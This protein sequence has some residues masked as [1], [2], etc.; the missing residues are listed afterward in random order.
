MPQTWATV[1]MLKEPPEVVRDF[2]AHH[3]TLG[4]SEVHLYFDDPDDPSIALVSH[5]SQVRVVRCTPG[6]WAGLAGRLPSHEARQKA[7]ANHALDRTRCDWIIHLDADEMV[8]GEGEIAR[9]L[10]DAEGDALR[11]PPFEALG[12]ERA[13]QSGRPEFRFRGPLPRGPRGL[14]IGEAAYGEFAG[15]LNQ[16]MLGHSAGKFFVRTRAEGLRLSIHGPFRNGVRVPATDAKGM[17]LLH[18]HGADWA[19][20]RRHLEFRLSSGA[21][22]STLQPRKARAAPRATLFDLLVGLRDREGEEGLRRFHRQVCTFGPE[23]RVLGRVG[24]LFE[25]DLWL[26]D[27]RSQVFDTSDRIPPG[28]WPFAVER[29]WRGLALRL[30]PDRCARER[31]LAR[32]RGFPEDAADAFLRA[33]AGR[34]LFMTD[35][36]PGLGLF[37]LLAARAGAAGSRV[38]VIEPDEVHRARLA[39]RSA[40]LGL[41][42]TIG[43]QA[44]SDARGV[45][46]GALRIVHIDAARLDEF[47]DGWRLFSGSADLVLV[48]QEAEVH[49]HAASPGRP[50][51]ADYLTE[52][53]TNRQDNR[54]AARTE[55]WTNS[56]P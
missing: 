16:G 47:G 43:S 14:R 7:N 27:K 38:L 17:R 48:S 42:I 55:P 35:F 3:V 31:S 28:G 10:E 18:F 50:A 41:G 30:M 1:T 6:H 9:C 44:V 45:P 15:S 39:E 40:A 23:K 37:A 11:L 2:V 19:K 46:N 53:T 34:V 20:W 25:A 5:I 26:A 21:Y 32:G 4:A 33:V 8:H 49:L 22:A 56:P 12:L 24:A 13:G 36:G 54:L 29:T 51:V 52:Q